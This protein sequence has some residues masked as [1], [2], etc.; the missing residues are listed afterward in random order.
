MSGPVTIPDIDVGRVSKLLLK[1]EAHAHR[2]GWDEPVHMRVIFDE[3]HTETARTL[4]RIAPPDPRYAPVRH[5]GYAATTFFG[6]RVLYQP[7]S[8]LP[9]ELREDD[10]D[11][12][13]TG[14]GPWT[15]LRHL[16]MGIADAEPDD[17]RRELMLGILRLPGVLG[18]IV[19][20]EGWRNESKTKD[21][22]LRASRREVHLSDLPDSV[23]ARALYCL[24]L[25]GRI[26][27]VERLRGRK[28]ELTCVDVRRQVDAAFTDMDGDLRRAAATARWP[29]PPAPPDGKPTLD[30]NALMRGDFTTSMR[31]LRDAVLDRLPQTP[32]AY[33]TRYPTLRACLEATCSE[34]DE[35]DSCPAE[36]HMHRPSEFRIVDGR[37]RQGGDW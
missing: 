14:P 5:D 23:E 31:I 20:G 34:P 17:E 22:L 4:R 21:N 13:K 29:V 11:K 28:P 9:A 33:A 2:Q 35:P 6:H 27:L 15:T 25:A 16:V 26:Q 32:E 8:E 24:D 37:W 3:S 12:D 18:F 10:P 19:V 30:D 7:W 1:V 36:P